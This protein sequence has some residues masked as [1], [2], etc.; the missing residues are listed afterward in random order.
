MESS[1]GQKNLPALFLL[2]DCISIF[3]YRLT[4]RAESNLDT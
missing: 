1:A 2:S 4:K 3:G